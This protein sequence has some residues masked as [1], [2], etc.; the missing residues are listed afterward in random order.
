MSDDRRDFGDFYPGGGR[1]TY[2]PAR[3]DALG[4]VNALAERVD[5]MKAA[6]ADVAN[7]TEADSLGDVKDKLA[8]VKD[9]IEAV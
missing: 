4:E 9:A 7:P 1:A 5:A 8:A 2:A 3:P 6:V